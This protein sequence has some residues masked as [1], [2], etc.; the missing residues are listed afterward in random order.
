VD[1]VFVYERE[2]DNSDAEEDAV[3]WWGRVY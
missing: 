3:T 2:L 1:D